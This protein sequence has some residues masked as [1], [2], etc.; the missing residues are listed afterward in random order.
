MFTG[1]K[2]KNQP[3]PQ[4]LSIADLARMAKVLK[5]LAHPYRL[6]I[7]DVLESEDSAPVHGLMDR[8]DLPQA[9]VSG[10]LKKMLRAGLVAAER[11]GK[12][13]WY[14]LGDRRSLTILNCMR[15]KKGARP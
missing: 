8:L 11:R 3:C 5:L 14:S 13:V 12:E 6:K 9:A 2:A 4:D 7:V 10:H 1:V 15:A